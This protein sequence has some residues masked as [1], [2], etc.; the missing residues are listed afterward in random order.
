[1]AK[2]ERDE[3]ENYIYSLRGKVFYRIQN[4]ILNGVYKP[5]ES[6]T[7]KKLS[8]DL[9]VSRTPIREA[10]MQLELEGLVKSVPNK[11]AVVKEITAKDIKE[12]YTI[13]MMI[14]G[15]AA[16]WA[17]DNI[18][19]EEL[20]ELKEAVDFEEFYTIKNDPEH[21]MKFDSKFHEILF[22]ASKSDP[23]MHLLKTFHHYVHRARIGSF[24]SPI[25]AREALKEHRAILDAIINKDAKMAEELAIEHIRNAASAYSH[26]KV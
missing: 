6:L 11:G 26:N 12:I 22:K 20:D 10:I 13:R 1:M 18:T 4:D 5:G 25:R 14:E 16:R 23:L 8:E 17:A 19:S 9:G 15:L 24:K 7:E 21:L 2:I 3:S